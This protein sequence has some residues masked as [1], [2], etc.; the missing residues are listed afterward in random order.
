[1]N[2]SDP[3]LPPSPT[4][5]RPAAISFDDADDTFQPRPRNRRRKKRG[6]RST[7]RYQLRLA[8]MAAGGILAAYI[9]FVLILKILHPYR[10]GHEVSSQVAILRTRLD[11][12]ESENAL[13]RRR[14]LFLRTK[15]GAEVTARR[16]GY[17]RKGETVYLLPVAPD[18]PDA[19]TASPAP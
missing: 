7:L 16:S 5:T 3:S 9:A 14:I 2:P 6:L 18:S 11:R 17:H 1:M 13:L 12:E 4:R 10:L 15:E 8:V 19:P